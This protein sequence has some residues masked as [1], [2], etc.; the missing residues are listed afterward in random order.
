MKKRP[1]LLLSVCAAI[2]V[3][4]LLP[5]EISAQTTSDFDEEVVTVSRRS[6]TQ[7]DVVGNIAVLDSEVLQRI[8]ATHIQDALVR[9]PGVNFHQ[10]NGQ[11]YLPSIRSA[12]LTGAGACGEFLTA[13]D[14][15]PLRAAGFCN[16]NELF[17]ANT[18]TAERIEV[19]RGPSNAL[20]G[21]NAMHGVVNVLLPRSP[22]TRE[23]QV[24]VEA[25]PNDY[26]RIKLLTGNTSGSHGYVANLVAT[27]D[28]G[29]RND[30]YYHQQ[31]MQ[32]RHDY[33]NA[34]YRVAT[35]FTASNLNQ[36][37][38]GYITG[39]E[40][41]K[42]DDLIKSNPEPEA[43][44]DAQ[45]F[46]LYS[47]VE[48]DFAN[49]QMLAVT[50]YFRKTD[51]EF[52]QHFLPGDPLEENGQD[53][54]GTM[55]AW[56]GRSDSALR[57]IVGMDMEITD[58]YLIESQDNPTPGSP[59]LEET[60]PVGLH[61]DYSVDAL[62]LAPYFNLDWDVTDRW[63]LNVGMRYETL[64]YDYD[65]RMLDGRTRDDGTPCGFGGCR[66]S[67]PSDSHDDY[68]N[69]SPKLGVMYRINDNH[70]AY[71]TVANGFRAPQA[72][73]L[74]RLQRDQTV[75]D[76][77]SEEIEGLELGFRGRGENYSYETAVYQMEKK[78][79]IFRDSD[80]FNVSNGE[81]EH[82]GVE[83][84]Y[85]YQ[86]NPQWRLSLVANYANHQYANNSMSGGSNINGNREDGA[87][88]HFG[89]AQ[90]NW[91]IT[92][93][94]DVE[95][96]A[97]HVG[98]YYTDPENEHEYEGHDLLNLRA[99]WQINPSWNLSLRVLN[100]LDENYAERADYA[101]FQGDRYFP[102]EPRS[103]YLQVSFRN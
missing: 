39:F 50:P 6:Q 94:I 46:R 48:K 44:R 27:H 102:G 59:F 52:L 66:F 37:T 86:F 29:F 88:Q 103:F 57:W 10:G 28:G 3:P 81:T 74:Y 68:N 5:A 26:G 73:E 90:L 20:Y 78:N 97:V 91:F 2:A 98:A 13:Q 40:A 69:F 65:N 8:N 32:L 9:V 16:V 22:L 87:P 49:G 1:F 17:E 100:L 35:T 41:Y 58:S 33:D 15:I 83:V 85:H 19:I 53:S 14:Y 56:Y 63:Q 76:L 12:V 82:F 93:D 84:N 54:F 21:S 31:K 67:R 24:G 60:I 70:R 79:V 72:T 34:D 80:F 96:E 71:F 43:Y 77:E 30:A 38:A 36:E 7:L 75:A 11:E 99:N 47:R 42:D 45:S 92:N 18:E 55:L 4:V 51:M 101:A 25:G 89:S 61:Y 62:Q 95:F 64:S 23:Y